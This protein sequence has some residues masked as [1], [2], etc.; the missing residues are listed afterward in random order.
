MDLVALGYTVEELLNAGAALEDII[1]LGVLTQELLNL[2]ETP[3]ALFNAG[4][5]LDSL[6]GKLYAGGMIFYLDT[7]TGNGLVSALENQGETTWGCAGTEIMGADDQS[8][9]S[10][11]LNTFDILAGCPTA[12]IA[13]DTCA[14]L[15]LNGFDD[16][17]LPSLLELKEM[18]D[19]IG[20]G[21]PAPNTNIGGFVAD[22]HWSSSE[23]NSNSAI[24][25]HLGNGIVSGN[26][27]AATHRVHAI[28]AF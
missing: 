1:A 24:L 5:I 21:A 6:Y 3:L 4:I 27:K 26:T 11:N 16:W 19:N 2:G 13:A 9:G 22:F 17:F 20:S 12:G 23:Q 18:D 14:N 28:R 25:R 15:V 8:V 7:A 10:G